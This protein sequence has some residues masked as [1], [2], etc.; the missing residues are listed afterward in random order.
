MKK[1]IM[2][3]KSVCLGGESTITREGIIHFN[4]TEKVENKAIVGRKT[5]RM[6]RMEYFRDGGYQFTPSQLLKL[7]QLAPSREKIHDN[8][9]LRIE[10]TSRSFLVH[11][12][13]PISMESLDLEDALDDEIDNAME[14]ITKKKE[15][16][17][18]SIL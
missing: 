5:E 1:V 14:I 10:M 11:V 7:M 6:G 16:L 4:A 15:D 3:A 2:E 17:E 13:L 18:C 12:K 9:K 8:G